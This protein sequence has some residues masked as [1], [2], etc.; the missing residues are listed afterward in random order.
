MAQIRQN[1]NLPILGIGGVATWRDAAEYMCV[2]ADVVQVCTEV[3]V[4]GYAIID[5]MKKGLLSYLD[6]KGLNSP[7]DLKNRAVGKLSTHET[8]NKQ[9]RVYPRIDEASC[10]K[11]GKCITICTESE[12]SALALNENKIAVNKNSCIGCSLCAHIC[13]K[14]AIKMESA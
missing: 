4:N 9:K 12:H 5:A 11:C 3:M 7:A 8:L 2:G 6:S 10:V 13:P 14:C 1:S